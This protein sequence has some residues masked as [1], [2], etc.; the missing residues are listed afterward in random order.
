MKDGQI[1]FSSHD[2]MARLGIL[3][4]ATGIGES[5]RQL[6]GTRQGQHHFTNFVKGSVGFGKT[7]LLEESQ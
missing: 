3:H 4:L 5:Q 2:S 1:A 7:S 6:K